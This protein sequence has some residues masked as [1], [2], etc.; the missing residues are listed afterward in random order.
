M[1]APLR[2]LMVL[3]VAIS[4]SPVRADSL[5]PD[6]PGKKSPGGAVIGKPLKLKY[7]NLQGKEVDL[8][9]FKGKVVLIDFWATWCGLCVNE[10]PNV[11]AA[12]NK[13]KDRG[14][15]IMGISLDEDKKALLKFTKEHKMEWPQYFDG[16]EWDNII[17][18]RF[19][20]AFIPC[21]WL[22]D[23]KGN[24]VTTNAGPELNQKIE[25]LL[26]RP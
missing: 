24:L 19:G 17:A 4:L 2:S 7:A 14:F 25:A 13:Y 10:M 16:K 23:K 18:K 20:V 9:S 15:A 12:Y 1:K 8:A 6:P 21:M 11:V 3:A 5:F 26:K 22:I